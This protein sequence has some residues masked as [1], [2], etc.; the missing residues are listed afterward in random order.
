MQR[1][2]TIT[3][4][5]RSNPDRRLSVVMVVVVAAIIVDSQIGYIADFIPEQLSSNTGIFVFIL[6]AVIFAITQ[7][8]ILDY[9]KKSSRVSKQRV[10]H[11]SKLHVGVSVAQYLLVGVITI[12][13]LQLLLTQQYSI[14]ALY[15]VHVI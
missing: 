6:I 8:L 5:S 2:K 1:I 7:Y 12:V 4:F 10:P 11:L 9:V 13:I 3:V 15:I 14:I